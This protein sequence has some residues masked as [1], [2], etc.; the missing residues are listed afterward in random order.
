M[1]RLTL[2]L[3]LFALVA[4]AQGRA[5]TPLPWCGTDTSAIDRAPDAVSGFA[6]HVAYVFPPGAPDRF[7]EWAPRLT[8]DVAAIEA[9]WRN[10]DASRAPRFDLHAFPCTSS[11]G[12]LDL[13]RIQLSA[14]VGQVTSAFSR[15][16]L[17]LASE[18]GL[19][20]SEKV[21]LVYYDGPTGQ[22]G[23]ER[24]CGQADEGRIGVSGLALV[25]LDSCG[26]EEGDD[27]R[28]VVAVHELVHALGGVDRDDA[29][30]ACFG[31]H[32]CDE[33]TDLMTAILADGPLE[34]RVLDHN[35]DDY[36]GHAGSWDDL[37][38]SRYLERLDSPDRAAPSTPSALSITNDRFGDVRF[39][40]SPAT[41][42][43]GPV[44]YRVSRDGFFV[45]EV[46]RSSLL[47]PALLGSTSTY[48][49]RAVDAVGRLSV[50]VFLR[51]TAG[52]GIVDA[53]GQL[54]RDTVPPAPVTQVAV[55]KLATRLVLTWARA[56]DAG[57]LRGYRLRVGSRIQTTTR[58][59]LTVPRSRL[60]GPVTIVAI[61]KAGNVGPATTVSLRRLR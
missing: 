6:V 53:S 14:Q 21:Y 10:Q 60:T 9:W 54:L 8:G 36:Y 15:I 43:V 31:G 32:V 40:W 5:S 49:V 29:P 28:P 48:S 56:R 61:D 20:Q 19:R 42:D 17:L 11:F 51:F 47:L 13:S 2:G 37:Q 45:D 22:I 38:D 52:L 24:I 4:P 59:T 57:G 35:R 12:R 55:R 25:Y 7:S 41:D 1:K 34:S 18:H 33:G 16:R 30:S 58:E 39:S 27:L 23:R 44:S 50:P 26:S 46:M 3:M